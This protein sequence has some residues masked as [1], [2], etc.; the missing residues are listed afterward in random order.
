MWILVETVE[1][2]ESCRDC[3]GGGCVWRVRIVGGVGVC[4]FFS[5]SLSLCEKKNLVFTRGIQLNGGP[6]SEKH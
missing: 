6:P 2:V 3:G 5:L 4:I 1:T